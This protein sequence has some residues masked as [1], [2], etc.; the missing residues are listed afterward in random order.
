MGYRRFRSCCNQ[1]EGY[2]SDTVAPARGQHDAEETHR[3]TIVDGGRAYLSWGDQC[4]NAHRIVILDRTQPAHDE[5]AAQLS[6]EY[7]GRGE[8][9]QQVMWKRDVPAG[10][11][12]L[13]WEDAL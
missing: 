9:E 13:M 1:F 11:E 5:A 12:M 3:V 8:C 10:V 2:H 4:P 7:L 6:D